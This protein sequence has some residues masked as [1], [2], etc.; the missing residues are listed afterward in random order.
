MGRTSAP[1]SGLLLVSSFSRYPEAIEWARVSIDLFW[2][3]V[4]LESPPLPFGETRYYE[5]TMGT[6]LQLRIF[7]AKERL[8]PD[9][10]ANLKIWTNRLE[11]IYA[12]ASHHREVR[13]LNLDPGFLTPAKFVL[14]TTKDASHRI[15][16]HSG[17]YAEV[18]LAYEH[19]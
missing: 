10:L 16:L 2:G 7:C 8:A 18:T 9:L 17:I 13:P 5:P 11:E 3:P 6:D 4:A 14:A 15:H 19:G 12:E 1:E